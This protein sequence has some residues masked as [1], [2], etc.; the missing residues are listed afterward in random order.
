MKGRVVRGVEWFKRRVAAVTTLLSL[1]ICCCVEVRW[2]PD[3]VRDEVSGSMQEIG[4]CRTNAVMVGAGSWA[5]GSGEGRE[6]RRND[7]SKLLLTVALLVVRRESKMNRFQLCCE[8]VRRQSRQL[9]QRGIASSH[10]AKAVNDRASACYC[11]TGV[12]ERGASERVWKGM[13]T[14]MTTTRVMVRWQQ[15][16]GISGLALRRF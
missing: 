1:L 10:H 13:T 12:I 14:V 16:M 8:V 9:S 15:Q 2:C 5:G 4:R 6:Q 7:S 3:V 11:S